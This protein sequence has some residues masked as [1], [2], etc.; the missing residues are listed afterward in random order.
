MDG[1]PFRINIRTRIGGRT[2][3]QLG[4]Q[5]TLESSSS[6]DKA[7]AEQHQGRGLRNS[8]GAQRG[9]L[10]GYDSIGVRREEERNTCGIEGRVR[11]DDRAAANAVVERT[12]Q[13]A[14]D[15][16]EG[17]GEEGVAAAEDE[18]GIAGVVSRVDDRRGDYASLTR[19]EKAGEVT[20]DGVLSANINRVGVE[21]QLGAS[22]LDRSAGHGKL[23]IDRSG[24]KRWGDSKC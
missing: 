10:E 18:C 24:M 1:T 2:V 21:D 7:G 23:T 3:L 9:C 11:R 12:S 20:R 14:G 19:G 5:A 8:G 4:V 15:A 22:V 6:A 16:V 13:R 17:Q